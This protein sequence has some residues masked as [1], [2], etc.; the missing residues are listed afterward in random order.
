[1]WKCS[2][3]ATTVVSKGCVFFFSSLQTLLL[4]SCICNPQKLGMYKLVKPF[5]KKMQLRPSC[6]EED[7]WNKKAEVLKKK[8]PTLL[9]TDQTLFLGRSEITYKFN[10]TLVFLILAVNIIPGSLWGDLN[11]TLKGNSVINYLYFLPW[12]T[13]SCR[14]LAPASTRQK[15]MA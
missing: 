11:V 7:S 6:I 1:M 9:S 8:K 3:E 14:K 4:M 15:P 10:Q 12:V 13:N 5:W 2:K